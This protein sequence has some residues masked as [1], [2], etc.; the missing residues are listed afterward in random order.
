M[1][2]KLEWR[3]LSAT[4]RSLGIAGG[5]EPR[6]PLWLA[7]DVDY[8]VIV[9]GDEDCPAPAHVALA[10][11]ASVSIERIVAEATRHLDAFVDRAK[12]GPLQPWYFEG[13]EISDL[14]AVEIS[15]LFTLE[16]DIYGAWYVAIR[17][18]SEQWCAV[19]F[20]REQT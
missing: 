12:F 15:L 8:E 17:A 5:R 16:A 19:G 1:S 13:F 20:R 3:L 10:E 6:T 2:G 7:K 4:P 18:Q 9:A 11:H 14:D